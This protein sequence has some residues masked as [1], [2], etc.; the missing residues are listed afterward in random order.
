M[1]TFVNEPY[2]VDATVLNYYIDCLIIND[3]LIAVVFLNVGLRK[4][5]LANVNESLFEIEQSK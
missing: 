2:I 1:L 4:L 3:D 5:K